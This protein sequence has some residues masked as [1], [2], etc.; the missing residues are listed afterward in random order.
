MQLPRGRLNRTRDLRVVHRALL[1]TG[2]VSWLG[3]PAACRG[4]LR[5]VGDEMTRTLNRLR[6]LLQLHRRGRDAQPRGG[7]PA[8]RELAAASA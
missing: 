8:S 4:A 3:E 1:A 6:G 2:R 7:T 5:V